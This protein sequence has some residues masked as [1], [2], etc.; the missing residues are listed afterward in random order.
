MK[1]VAI[2]GVWAY[3]V[4][5][6]IFCRRNF[7]KQS[8]KKYGALVLVF[9]I[10]ASVC[11]MFSCRKSGMFI[12]EIYTYGLSNSHYAPFLDDVKGGSLADKTMTRQ[13]LLDYVTVNSGEGFDFGSVYYN[14]VNDVHPPLYYWLF[15]I[16]SSFTPDAFSKWTGLILDFIIFMLALIVLYKLVFKLFGSRDNAVIAVALYGLSNLGLSTMLMIRMYVLLT[17]LTLTLAYLIACLMEKPRNYLYPLIGLNIFLGLMTQYYFVFYAFFIC[18]AYLIYALIRKQ[19]KPAV[20]FSV[21][22]LLGVG[23][24]LVFFPA[25]LDHLFSGKL[26]SGA[27]ALEN[28]SAVDQYK[29]RFVFFVGQMRQGLKAAV[30]LTLL[31]F[32][33]LLIFIKKIVKAG[34]D[35]VLTLDSLVIIVPALISFIVVSIIS[36]VLEPRYIYN[37][38]PVFVIA[39][40]FLIYLLEKSLGDFSHGFVIKKACIGFALLLALWF[41]RCI[42]P[43]Y[44]YPEYPEYDK[45]A[46]QHSSSPCIYMTDDHFEP[47]TQD[48][49]QLLFFDSFFM[50]ADPESTALDDYLAQFKDSNECV[51]YID[52]S[53]FWSSGFVPEEMLP[54]LIETTD[55]NNYQPLYENGLSAAYLLIK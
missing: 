49:Q 54:E 36:P 50:A 16:A 28:L 40:S 46:A 47:I 44:L 48:L 20:I 52:R 25:C 41:A 39:V 29:E 23:C 6:R 2:V 5:M 37:I 27:N 7:M 51:V 21:S 43:S 45:L 12:D 8:L 31:L 53:V 3:T 55:F 11:L 33:L 1:S 4:L 24:L 14:Q 38:A 13:D 26:V 30:C 10:I 19:Y 22:A 35:G 17:L 15:N 9:I 34:K 18:L 42:P 32:V